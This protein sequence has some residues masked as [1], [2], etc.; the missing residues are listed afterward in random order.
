MSSK[1]K[2]FEKT[3]DGQKVKLYK[4]KHFIFDFGGVLVEQSYTDKNFLDILEHDLG[5]II[6]RD[7][8]SYTTKIN[9]LLKAGMISSRNYVEKILDEYY[10]PMQK[11]D[12][13]LPPKKVNLD[14]YLE[15]WFQMYTKLTNFSYSMEK[16]IG[17]LHQAGFIVSL[18]SNTFDIHAKSNELRGF[19][20]IFDN[21]Y[22]SN[23]LGMIKPDIEKYKYV[24]KKLD[25]KGKN[26]VFVD[27]KISNLVPARKVGMIIL[28]FESV[29]K[30]DQHLMQLGIADL[31]K[32]LLKEIQNKYTDYKKTKKKY[33]KIKKE[34]GKSKKK[35]KKSLKNN[36]K[37][38]LKKMQLASHKKKL[39]EEKD[40]VEDLKVKIKP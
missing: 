1:D 31:R 26:C 14:Y 22:L 33:K 5:I 35:K 36:L 27:D 30:F 8:K 20:E 39:K 38:R 15:L 13:A 18:L 29:E 12:S 32:G 23:E 24:L 4:I 25:T 2:K 7:L 34:Y 37:Y 17:K 40:T 3:L 28:R 21:V 16:C 10:Y 6:P 11:K 9:R 19:Y